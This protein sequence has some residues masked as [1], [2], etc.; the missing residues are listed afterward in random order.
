MKKALQ[1][2]T[3]YKSISAL[4][5]TVLSTVSKGDLIV[6]GVKEIQRLTGFSRVSVINLL[7][8]LTK[9]KFVIRLSRDKYCLAKSIHEN[10]FAVAT[11]TFIPSYVS[12]WSAL[13]FYGFTEQQV[14]VIQLAST[15]QFKKIKLKE[16][17]IQPITVKPKKFFGYI[18]ENGFSIASREKALID[19]A[20]NFKYVGG[21]AEFTKCFQNAWD[22]INKDLFVR[23]LLK[24]NNNSLNSRIGFLIERLNL[25][26]QKK[27]LQDIQMKCSSGFIK[28]NIAK[29]HSQNYNKKWKI[30]INDLI[31][32]E[33]AS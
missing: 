33:R 10:K 8:S 29:K 18:Q 30:I 11:N 5:N 20:S 13:S 26:I 1:R 16:I 27:L 7:V 21:F 6:F 28:L 4:E 2:Y 14:A 17:I 3:I 23:Y 32:S 9:K 25:S 31:E 12:F 24:I 22:E 19:S 15:K